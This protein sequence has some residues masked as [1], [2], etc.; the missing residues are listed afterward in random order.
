MSVPSNNF[1]NQQFVLK[2]L[3]DS[4]TTLLRSAQQSSNPAIRLL[5]DNLQQAAAASKENDHENAVKLLADAIVA[6]LRKA[7]QD[8]VLNAVKSE[9]PPLL[10]MAMQQVIG[11]GFPN[12]V[13]KA[14]KERIRDE[15][16]EELCQDVL[17]SHIEDRKNLEERIQQ[18]G[19]QIETQA[20]AIAR[21][22]DSG[23]EESI[24][25]MVAPGFLAKMR[26]QSQV[27]TEI[28][29]RVAECFFSQERRP[30]FAMASSTIVHFGLQLRRLQSVKGT[31]FCTNSVVFPMVA[32]N[33]RSPHGVYPFWGRNYDDQCGGWYPSLGDMPYFEHLRDCF[34][35]DSW[36]ITTSL[37]TPRKLSLE[38]GLYFT[39]AES[40]EMART[41]IECSRDVILML[42][43]D[44]LCRTLD[45][46][47]QS[48]T[49]PPNANWRSLGK[50]IYLV[51][52][53][54]GQGENVNGLVHEAA[55]QG[56][57]V[58]YQPE[59]S[60]SWQVIQAS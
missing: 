16:I 48:N 10:Q 38:Y 18:L 22:T 5:F 52:A 32:L 26:E 1:E 11:K 13:S 33:D 51:I 35:P 19:E 2:D 53:G 25:A 40:T 21:L 37:I 43:A 14:L 50:Q 7:I 36:G 30:A 54:V 49:F 56:I 15:V 23:V 17:N 46:T 6:P 28:G 24:L 34:R 3:G 55:R 39:K 47:E 29:R 9:L 8:D 57:Q 31:Q 58:H 45:S 12:L 60:T 41:I 20:N 59:E 44:R 42:P 27:K 4:W